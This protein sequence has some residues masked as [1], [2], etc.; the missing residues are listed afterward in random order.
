MKQ[1][2]ERLFVALFLALALVA[3]EPIVPEEPEKSDKAELTRFSFNKDNNPGLTGNISAVE[4]NG[5]YCISVNEGMDRA[6]LVPTVEVSAG[7]TATIDG[8]PYTPGTAYDFSGNV[9]TIVVTSES[10]TRHKEYKVL[11]KHG[12]PYIDNSI[13]NGVFYHEISESAE[14]IANGADVTDELCEI[15]NF[16]KR[17][18]M[19]DEIYLKQGAKEDLTKCRECPRDNFM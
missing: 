13:Y 16:V 3:C 10:E 5:Y 4:A 12:N 11:V 18:G 9:Q 1:L 15:C 8:K 19:L 14:R 17:T 2:I 6:R 7:A